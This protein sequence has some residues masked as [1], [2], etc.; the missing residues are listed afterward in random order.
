MN[1]PKPLPISSDRKQPSSVLLGDAQSNMYRNQATNAGAVVANNYGASNYDYDNDSARY[2]ADADLWDQRGANMTQ[3]DHDACFGYITAAY[4]ALAGEHD[5]LG[6]ASE[7]MA[8]GEALVAQG[9]ALQ[10]PNKTPKYQ[11]ALLAY[12]AAGMA[13]GQA[14][15]QHSAFGTPEDQADA[16]KVK[17]G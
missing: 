16:I 9:D 4:A 3:A 17:Y 12:Y 1:E 13:V 11:A 14:G 7:H 8:T 15:Q 10:D 6:L 2:L 5:K